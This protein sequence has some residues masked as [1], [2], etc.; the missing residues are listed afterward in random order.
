M[1]RKHIPTRICPH[2]FCR[3][4]HNASALIAVIALILLLVHGTDG[5]SLGQASGFWLFLA[6]LGFIG[7]GVSRIVTG[8]SVGQL[9]RLD[10]ADQL[11]GIVLV[12]RPVW[13]A[14][15]AGMDALLL[16]GVCTVG[17]TLL[18]TPGA[19]ITSPTDVARRRRGQCRRVCVPGLRAHDGRA[20]GEAE[21]C[22]RAGRSGGLMRGVVPWAALVG[23]ACAVALGALAACSDP[24]VHGT[25]TGKTYIPA[26]TTMQMEPYYG[27][28]C[29]ME[30]VVVVVN[31][32][33]EDE[34]EDVCNQVVLGERLT[35]VTTPDCWQVTVTGK[36]GGSVCVT[37]AQY[38]AAKLGGQW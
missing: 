25:V 19:I 16:A 11:R 8:R 24:A 34:D 20:A 18:A 27:Q 31:G 26:A 10:R 23:V 3:P 7:Y 38:D 28:R 4:L 2:R 5:V 37:Q 30:I 9:A 21:A 1:P 17:A 36:Q 15:A 12:V 6:I 14:I 29:T 22:D 35:P 33:D 32:T 13:A